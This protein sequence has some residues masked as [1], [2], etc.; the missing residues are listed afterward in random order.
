MPKILRSHG[1]WAISCACGKSQQIS[2]IFFS[3]LWFSHVKIFAFQTLLAKHVQGWRSLE[4][5]VEEPLL[6]PLPPQV[7]MSQIGT[8]SRWLSI[9]IWKKLQL[10]NFFPTKQALEI[11]GIFTMKSS[12]EVIRG[13][14]ILQSTRFFTHEARASQVLA[15]SW[16]LG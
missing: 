9:L 15:K 10:S 2:R 1:L 14:V 8:S 11:H 5:G 3:A 12:N 4:I 6:L 16:S 7:G 13:S